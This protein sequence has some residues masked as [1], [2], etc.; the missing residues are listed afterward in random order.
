MGG[1]RQ[2]SDRRGHLNVLMRPTP[3]DNVG[4]VNDV[5][6]VTRGALGQDLLSV[7]NINDDL[8]ALRERW[9]NGFNIVPDA[10]YH[11]QN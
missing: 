7:V 10:N 5:K 2:D 9:R 11:A 4:I 1:W 6:P 8:L 3:T